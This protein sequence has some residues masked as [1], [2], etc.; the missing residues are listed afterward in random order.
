MCGR[1]DAGVKKVIGEV[2][3]GLDRRPERGVAF[4]VE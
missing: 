2:A 3:G 1:L 4:P